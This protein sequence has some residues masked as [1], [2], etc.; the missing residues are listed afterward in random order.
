MKRSPCT[1]IPNRGP[2]VSRTTD[3]GVRAAG[4]RR[5]P[6]RI[7]VAVARAYERAII[8]KWKRLRYPD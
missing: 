5:V 6:Q 4:E 2:I 3:A 8:A 1:P 7:P